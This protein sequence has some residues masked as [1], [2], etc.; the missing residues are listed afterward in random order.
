MRTSSSPSPSS[1][2]ENPRLPTRCSFRSALKSLVILMLALSLSVCKGG[3]KGGGITDPQTFDVTVSLTIQGAGD[4]N[5]QVSGSQLACQ[6]Q[7]GQAAASGCQRAFTINSGNLPSTLTLT[8]FPSTESAFVTWGGACASAGTNA[9]CSL[10]ATPTNSTFSASAQ[11]DL[12]PG[13]IQVTTVTDGQ[14]LDDSYTVAIGQATPVTVGA[15]AI[16]T[17]GGL[18][19]GDYAV[20]LGD[21]ADNCTL[22]G[23]N[24]RI[25]TV[26]AGAD[27]QAIFNVTCVPTTG[28]IEVTT[29]TSG[30]AEDLDDQY[31]VAI[32]QGAPTTLDVNTTETFAQ[33]TPGDHTV[34]L[35]GIASN[36]TLDDG[37]NPRTLTVM[38]G[39]TTP[40]TFNLTCAPPPGSIEVTTVT[41]GE[42]VPGDDYTLSV[43]QGV[44]SSIGINATSTIGSLAPG[45]HMVT[46]GSVPGNCAVAEENPRTL[47]VTSGATTQTTF[48]VS[49]ERSNYIA[50]ERVSERGDRDICLLDPAVGEA[51]VHCITGGEGDTA[52]DIHAAWG[53]SQEWLIFASDRDGDFELYTMKADG[54][55]VTQ[56][57]DNDVFDGDPDLYFSGVKAVFTSERS[58][59]KDIWE[60][61]LTQPG[62]PVTQVTTHGAGDFHPSYLWDTGYIAFTST[63][64]GDRDIWRMDPWGTVG[65]QTIGN[66]NDDDAWYMPPNLYYS[67]D[68]Y[69]GNFDIIRS[70]TGLPI[71]KFVATPSFDFQPAPGPDGFW[72][73]YATNIDGNFEIYRK[74]W[75][76]GEVERLTDNAASDFRP[77]WYSWW[78]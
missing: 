24:P 13:S 63:R 26:S 19:P 41:T 9:A 3:K 32:G 33:L 27:T 39:Q 77:A 56:L 50:F 47:A 45:D 2:F 72:V 54:S 31:T 43:D 46:L 30:N 20:T 53:P 25:L 29:F 59:N 71:E 44:G 21:I 37:E 16:Q 36:C 61:D 57:T 48:N 10:T 23:A 5:G 68:L 75:S 38:G 15:N 67:S 6:I 65:Q 14:D 8:A 78:P 70:P 7:G 40:T 62:Y 4:G 18:S 52:N 34:T 64:D 74:N 49:C 73:A 51:S 22:D 1:V 17:L 69:D 28:S 55:D 60:M 35:G 42:E 12:L 58:G 76:T 11:F 66:H